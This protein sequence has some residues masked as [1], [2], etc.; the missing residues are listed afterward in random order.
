MVFERQKVEMVNVG[1]PYRV[2]VAVDG[3]CGTVMGGER[4]EVVKQFKYLVTA[5]SKQ[6]EMEE[7]RERTVKSRSIM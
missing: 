4:M 5:L 3:W 7:V 6:G 1:N 2:S